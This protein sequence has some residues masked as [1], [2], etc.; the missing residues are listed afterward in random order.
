MKSLLLLQLLFVTVSSTFSQESVEKTS[1]EVAIRSVM[2]EQIRGWNNG[3]LESFMHGYS[4]S[5]S[6]RFASGGNVTYGWKTMLQRYQKSYS[7]KEKMGMLQFT[8]I[9]IDIISP[10]AAMVFGKWSLQRE[11]DAPWG[12]FTLLFKNINGEWRIVHDHTS[13]GN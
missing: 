10:Q 3:N 12:L 1:I 11:K 13:S 7:S 8:E 4:K 9:S 6:L 2:D 5:D